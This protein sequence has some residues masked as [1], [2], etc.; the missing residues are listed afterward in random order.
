MQTAS[1]QYLPQPQQQSAAQPLQQQ[2][3]LGGQYMGQQQLQQQPS[4]QQHEVQQQQTA[5]QTALAQILAQLAGTVPPAQ[6][7]AQAA[8]AQQMGIQAQAG[9]GTVQLPLSAA[10]APVP[11][12]QRERLPRDA[13]ATLLF[14]N[15]P[16]D[17]SKREASHIFRPIQGFKVQA[18]WGT[19]VHAAQGPWA[20]PHLHA[21]HMWDGWLGLFSSCFWAPHKHQLGITA[22]QGHA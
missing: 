6:Q 10:A 19:W 13:T 17:L 2:P 8:P 18:G 9:Y 7:Q 3:F 1:Q 15:L 22:W 5:Q 11:L 21:W 20:P 14:D 16:L 4:Q 12:E